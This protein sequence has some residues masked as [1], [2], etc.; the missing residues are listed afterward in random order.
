[1]LNNKIYKCK[2]GKHLEYVLSFLEGIITFISPCILPMF[3]IYLSYFAGSNKIVNRKATILNALGFTIGFSIV[4]ISMGAFAGAVGS[5][6]INHKQIV[7]FVSGFVMIL[8]GLNFIG[9]L[10]IPFINRNRQMSFSPVNLNFLSSILFGIVFSIGWTPCV[11]VFLGSALMMA[12][13]QGGSMKGILLL[14]CYS[15]GLSLPFLISAVLIDQLK[16]TF[17]FFKKNMDKI[18]LISGIFLIL[19]GIMIMFG[20]MGYLLSFFTF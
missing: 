12:A 18:S 13:S 6:L 10:K 4:F 11:G 19:I 20:Y 3:P 9:I 7:D 1:M 14:L 8:F 15:A 2:G 16:S 17:A 5:I